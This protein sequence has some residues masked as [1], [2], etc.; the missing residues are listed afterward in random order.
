MKDIL[1]D[2]G[3]IEPLH[4]QFNFK[5]L[6]DSTRCVTFLDSSDVVLIKLY[7]RYN[8]IDEKF[9]TW[10]S[11]GALNPLIY[12]PKNNHQPNSL[13][14]S[15]PVV[16]V[17]SEH[18]ESVEKIYLMDIE[19]ASDANGRPFIPLVGTDYVSRLIFKR[20]DNRLYFYGI[21]NKR[22]E[23]F[24]VNMSSLFKE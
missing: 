3:E 2:V 8:S 11:I 6:I 21:A 15:N 13:Q 7:D 24:E 9:V 17:F 18:S 19:L 14:H 5:T 10:E 22:L 23:V 20:L 1:E 12:D 16:Y 4:I